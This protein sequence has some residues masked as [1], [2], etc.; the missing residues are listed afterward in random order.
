MCSKE[1]CPRISSRRAETCPRNR[2]DGLPLQRRQVDSVRASILRL[3][4][5]GVR[6]GRID[7]R[8]E[9]VAAADVEAVVVRDPGAGARRARDAPVAVV[10]ETAA[11][12]VRVLHV[13]VD[14][15]ELAHR[16]VVAKQPALAAIPRDGHTAVPSDDQM[17]RVVGVDP[18]RVIL[19]VY[20]A[21]HV[22]EVLAAIVRN[23]EAAVRPEQVHAVA[24]SGI[25]ANLAVVHRARIQRGPL[26]PCLPAVGAAIH[27]AVAAGRLDRRVDDAW[28]AVKDVEA[29]ASLLARRQAGGELRPGGAAVARAI[30]PAAGPAAVESPR[31]ALPLIHR[32]EEGFR[33]AW[34]DHEVGRAGVVVHVE[35][36]PPRLPAVGRLEDAA[37]IVR[38]PQVADCSDIDDVRM[39]GMNDDPADVACI[40][41][42]RGLPGAAGIQRAIHAVA[43]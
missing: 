32:G 43:P 19:G 3:D 17:V 41:E 21:E 2:C 35:D 18:E 26:L 39:L 9:S 1:T 28:I 13:G 11:D 15:V 5:D 7:A 33:I 12:R 10:L 31:L 22:P 24:V 42:A 14:F 29:D 40:G 36:L 30:D 4:E 34:I 20:R 8:V 25:G 16:Q 23:V 6:I 37:L 27:A 38:S